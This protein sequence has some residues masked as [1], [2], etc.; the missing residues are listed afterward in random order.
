MAFVTGHIP[1][2]PVQGE[3]GQAV[4][5][6]SCFPVIIIMTFQARSTLDPE[7]SVV[8]FQVAF[9]AVD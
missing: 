2:F 5:E 7:L 3:I 6:Q 8:D 1:V 4:I 9:E